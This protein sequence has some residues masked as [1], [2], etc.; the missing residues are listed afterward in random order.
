MASSS[1][2]V[3]Q[4]SEG[5]Q[6]STVV[7]SEKDSDAVITRD[8]NPSIIINVPSSKSSAMESQE[9]MDNYK[10]NPKRPGNYKVFDRQRAMQGSSAGFG[11]DFFGKYQKHRTIELAR[12]RKMDEDKMQKDLEY[13]RKREE[14]IKKDIERT[15]KRRARRMKRKQ[16]RQKKSKQPAAAA[17]AS[18]GAAASSI[19]PSQG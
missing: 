16:N 14:H 13:H 2:S 3:G 12:L 8:G 10:N 15:E 7:N 17:A 9:A 5:L 11:S 1:S 6:H 18:G 19:P 4:L